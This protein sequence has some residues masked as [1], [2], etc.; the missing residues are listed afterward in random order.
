MRAFGPTITVGKRLRPAMQF[1]QFRS[2]V[3]RHRVSINDA[4]IIIASLAVAAYLAFEA[5]VF[6]TEG[7]LTPK[8]KT[9]ELD[10]VILL[11]AVLAIS[12]LVFCWR[13]Y[14]EQKRETNRRIAAEMHARE[15]AFQDALTGLAN[16]RQFDDALKAA[17][18]AP[19]KAGAAH[20]LFLLD[21]NGFKHVNDVYGHSVGDEVLVCVSQRLRSVVRESELVARFGGDEF[22]IL[23]THLAGPEA[24]SNISL[25]VIQALEE[26]IRLGEIDHQVGAG[27]G[28]ALLPEDATSV[29]EALRKADVALYR[30]KAERRSAMRFFEEDMDRLVRERE[31]ME[32]ELRTAVLADA[33]TMYYQ[34]SVN[35]VT[36]EV[37]GFE[38]VPRW[39]HPEIGEIPTE[40]FIPIA[41]EMGLIH[42]LGERLLRQACTT[43][44]L[45][46]EDIVLSVDAFAGQLTDQQMGSRILTILQETGLSPNRLEIEI[47]ESLLVRH[48]EAAQSIFG[49]LRQSGVRIALDNFGTGYSSLYHLRNFKLDKVKID[50]SFIE[51]IGTNPEDSSIVRALVGLGNGLGLTISAEGIGDS[52]QSR[53]L[54][55]S[56]CQQGQG[57]LFS[58]AINASETMTLFHKVA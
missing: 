35:L 41:E 33:I 36:K 47:T 24:A 34:P 39:I 49:I 52:E 15:L 22:A 20:A 56:G 19:P 46:P 57:D 8:Q 50:R 51:R 4:G 7:Q 31:H 21:L 14:I 58:E 29:Q 48:L 17:I 37:V 12:M 54:L 27:I 3:I 6:L 26:P 38:A 25:R 53:T 18:D 32:R 9:L 42:D 55:G 16:R 13:R 30:A 23:A 43:A 10:E 40:R 11:G 5:D 45:W 44:K 1:E 2:F 28:M